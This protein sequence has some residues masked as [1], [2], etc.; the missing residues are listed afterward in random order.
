M[1]V[2]QRMVFTRKNDQFIEI[3]GLQDPTSGTFFNGATVTA[4]LIDQYLQPVPGCTAI[5]LNYLAGTN[6]N[7]RGLVEQTFNPPLGVGYTLQITGSAPGQGTD[8]EAD[9]FLEIPAIVVPR[10]S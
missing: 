5:V 8:N 3:D 7:Y 9:L 1:G 10:V 4:T 6:G 2:P